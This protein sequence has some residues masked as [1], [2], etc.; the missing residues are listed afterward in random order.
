MLT[1]NGEYYCSGTEKAHWV[2]DAVS[3]A[4]R[5]PSYIEFDRM[6]TMENAEERLLHGDNPV[7]S[8]H[9][10]SDAPTAGEAIPRFLPHLPELCS[11]SLPSQIAPS[12]RPEMI[13][14]H[15]KQLEFFGQYDTR[16]WDNKTVVLPTDAVFAGI[17]ALSGE[18]YSYRVETRY[19]FAPSVFPNLRSLG[20][21]FDAKR[22]FAQTLR[23]LPHLIA[24]NVAAFDSIESLADILPCQE[25]VSLTLSWNRKIE[26]LAGIERFP[27]LRYLKLGSLTKLENLD[28]IESLQHLEFV[29]VY[30]SKRVEQADAL[31]T[32]PALK[33][34]DTFGIDVDHPTWQRVKEE[35]LTRGTKVLLTG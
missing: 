34:I 3:A 19:R 21:T 29:G 17:E 6:V 1:E 4:R 11:L 7:H 30:F 2:I 28:A 33:N 35:F 27:N 22:K 5:V 24:V 8:L 9:L 16:Y 23:E 12:L 14:M 18:A 20:F 10:A 31:R 32:L 15:V 25:L 26:S 13:G